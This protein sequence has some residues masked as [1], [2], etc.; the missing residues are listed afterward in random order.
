MHEVESMFSSNRVV[1][2]HGLGQV[3][4]G[5]PGSREEVLTAAGLD[6][7]VGEFPVT[8]ELPDGTKIT[9]PEK[10]GVVRLTDNSLL[11]IVGSG[12][13]PIQPYQLIDFAL[14]LLDVDEFK[15]NDGPPPILFES[16]LS[17]SEGRVNVLT[18]KVPTQI[19]VGGVDAVD[20]YLVFVNSFDGSLRFGVH[21]TPIR[22]VCMNTLN[23]SFKTAVQSWATK[24]TQGA[25]SSISEARRTL[26]L[27]WLYVES[28]QRE[29]DT[30]LDQEFTKRQFEQMVSKLFPKP[31]GERAPF[32]R[33]Q[34]SLIGLLES[35]PTID[36][37]FR[38]SKYGALNAVT[39]YMDWNTRFNEGGAPVEEKRTTNVLFGRAKVS[40]DKAFAYLTS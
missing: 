12:Y 40:T 30:L 33:E 38:Y 3:L 22:V 26:N 4:P 2:W 10:K 20:M 31:A 23:A 5:Y 27:T 13:T 21:A 1:P 18:C 16:G 8:V 7:Q 9:A 17:L 24:H 32:S 37:G 35:S 25:T 11:S 28:F 19:L 6:W 14:A 36:D 39:E 29:M 15:A 34:Y